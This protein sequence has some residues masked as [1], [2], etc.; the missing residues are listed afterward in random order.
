MVL[1]LRHRK[2]DATLIKGKW[3]AC[4]NLIDLLLKEWRGHNLLLET[5]AES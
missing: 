4:C 2:P 5:W 1:W 3:C